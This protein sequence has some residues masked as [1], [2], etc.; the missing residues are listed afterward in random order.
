MLSSF[1]VAFRA[2]DEPTQT[3]RA[4]YLV[5]CSLNFPAIQQKGLAITDIARGAD[6]HMNLLD[7]LCAIDPQTEIPP[8]TS[9]PADAFA[10][11][12]VITDAMIHT[13]QVDQFISSQERELRAC[14]DLA[15]DLSLSCDI[16][17][18]RRP[19]IPLQSP[20]EQ[21]GVSEAIDR[22][23]AI[24]SEATIQEAEPPD[25]RFGYLQPRFDSSSD[26]E[27]SHAHNKWKQP[28]GAR[29]LVSEWDLGANPDE[30]K[31]VDLNDPSLAQITVAPQAKPSASQSQPQSQLRNM[32][33][34]VISS[35][36]RST[37]PPTLKS[38]VPIPRTTSMSDF[39][40]ILSFNPSNRVIGSGSQVVSASLGWDPSPGGL[41]T[42]SQSQDY[43]EMPST[44]VLPGRFGGRPSVGGKKKP[45]KRMVGF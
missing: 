16:F 26:S 4:G 25:A 32:P 1:D 33:P 34:T 36:V 17:S 44:Q 3:S 40:H 43:D 30:Y 11:H 2:G 29:L 7:A 10:K 39:S 24:L 45:K 22:I 9:T 41:Q 28:L 12:R 15:L 18:A 21:D 38:T 6:W 31:Y 37:Q 5:G 42:Q 23:S 27:S 19:T 20:T 13:G 35:Q 14:D 8:I